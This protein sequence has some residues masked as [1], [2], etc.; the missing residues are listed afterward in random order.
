MQYADLAMPPQREPQPQRMLE[1]QDAWRRLAP[2][3][4][5]QDTAFL[6]NQQ[7]RTLDATALAHLK[8]EPSRGGALFPHLYAP[9]AMD[10]VLWVKPLPLGPDG[11]HDFPLP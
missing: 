9:L 8:W 10:E 2:A 4:H 3:L 7:P 1:D 11:T 6:S 5:V